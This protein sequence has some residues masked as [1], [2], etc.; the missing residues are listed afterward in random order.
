MKKTIF[1]ITI[2]ILSSCSYIND[3]QITKN[4]NIDINTF[5]L[6][7]D[8]WNNNQENYIDFDNIDIENIEINFDSEFEENILNNDEII[9]EATDEEI[10][11]LIDILFE[12]N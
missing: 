6:N 10:N 11:E 9:E 1:L 3:E 4:K 8:N 5:L 7:N 12:T 2:F